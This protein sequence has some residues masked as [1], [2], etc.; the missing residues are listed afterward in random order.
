MKT[1]HNQRILVGVCGSIAAYKSAELI[2]LLRRAEA[3]VRVMMTAA[4]CRF[5]P[6]LTL[7]ALSGERVAVELLD[8][9]NEARFGHIELARWA[10]QIVIAPASADIMA[11]LA[12]GM[13]DDLPAAVC[14]ASRAPLVLCPAM[15]HQM[16]SH[17]AT[18]ANRALLT[19]RGVAFI[20]PTS[21]E[22][23]C[24]ETGE[25]RMVEP[26][27]I[28]AAL[29][30]VNTPLAGA[31]VVITAGPTQEAIDPV[32]YLTNHSSGR[33]GY[34]VAQ[35]AREAG[36]EV[37]LISGPTAL[38]PPQSVV[39]RAVTSA[40]EMHAAVMEE[41]V[42]ADMFIAAAAV[43]D[44]R[45]AT[46]AAQKIKKEGDT[47]T[48]ELVKNPD[49]LAAVAALPHPPFCVGFA[50]ETENLADNARAK[51]ARKKL[52][53]IAANRV[54]LPGQG[55]HAERNALTLFWPGGARELPLA[56]KTELARQLVACITERWADIRDNDGQIAR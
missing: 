21:G 33:M 45:P 24:G 42:G 8:A 19:S 25:G 38:Q 23:A 30:P 20:G 14:L 41:I 39:T 53:L 5:I 40:A 6:P 29:T 36:A 49:I 4:A 26:A 32:R 10:D 17:P 15:N 28:V 22:Q 2:R 44:Y 51:L 47:L 13:A 16:W 43:A 48:V 55:F 52:H 18:Q 34:A 56:D 46:I 54:D 9:E 1:L 3:Q 35:A 11:R 31:R 27:A 50:A 7:Q 37:I 12:Q